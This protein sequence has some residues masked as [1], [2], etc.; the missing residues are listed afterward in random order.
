MADFSNSRSTHINT[1]PAVV[2]ALIN[3]FSEWPKWS[4]WEGLDP[5]LKRTFTGPDTGVG[6][7]YAWEGNHKAGTGTMEILRSEPSQIEIALEFLK[8]FKATN[9][10]R[11][12]FAPAAGGTDVVW[13]MTGQ[14][15]V[16]MNLMGKLYFDN[17]I[18]KDFE[19]GLAALKSAAESS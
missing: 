2:H 11:F 15:G 19:K 12:A 8:P 10:T 13:T 7:H 6:S 18:G 16:L 14:R 4:P 1:D 5:D 9:T 3:D 17:A